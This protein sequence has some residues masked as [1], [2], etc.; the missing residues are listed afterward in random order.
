MYVAPTDSNAD[1][2]AIKSDVGDECT[3]KRY[4]EIRL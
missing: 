3:L 2:S 4:A 1:I